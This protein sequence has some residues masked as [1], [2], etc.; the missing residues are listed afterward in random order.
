MVADTFANNADKVDGK[1]AVGSGASVNNRKGKLVAT[2]RNTGRLP[3]NIIKKAG[4]ANL[5]DGI[6]SD[7][8][9]QKT[10]NV[11]A[12]MLNGQTAEDFVA[13]CGVAAV[14]AMGYVN[15]NAAF[16][17]EYQEIPNDYTCY[18][19]LSNLRVRRAS[20]GV[21]VVDF[22]INQ[23]DPCGR[24][25]A[26]VNVADGSSKYASWR[27]FESVQPVSGLNVCEMDVR[28]WDAAGN[29]ADVPF[30]F[31]FMGFRA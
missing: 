16:P 13:E 14:A 20:A 7:F 25:I 8:F 5:F 1:H 2:N 21:Y 31:I 29:P 26:T 6:N 22:G 10:E 12:G 17:A 4:D 15:G 19:N 11:N 27:L 3:N 18:S 9:W 30:S 23:L 28:L 24:A